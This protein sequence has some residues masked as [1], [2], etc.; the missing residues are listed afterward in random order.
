M[1]RAKDLVASSFSQVF[2]LHLVLLLISFSFLLILSAPLVYMYLNIF[3][4]NF[5]K[6]DTW[7]NDVL[8]F[9]E[10]FIKVLAF[11]MTLPVVAASVAYLYYSL[12]EIMEASHLRQAIDSFGSSLKSKFARR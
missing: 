6:A 12:S 5:A 3:K 10:I 4:M 1:V 11:Y 9:V 8:Y 2:V 7:V